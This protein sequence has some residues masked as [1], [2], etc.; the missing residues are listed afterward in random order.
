MGLCEAFKANSS[1]IMVALGYGLYLSWSLIGS[2]ATLFSPAIE[3]AVDALSVRTPFE[4]GIWI[5]ALLIAALFSLRP[6][7]SR[8]RGALAAV[9]GLSVVLGTAA[10][11]VCSWLCPDLIDCAQMPTLLS[12]V[13]I[14]LWGE[15][16]CALDERRLVTCVSASGVFSFLLVLACMLAGPGVQA[17]LHV[18]MAVGTV[19]VF[20]ATVTA[21]M[22]EKAKTRNVPEPEDWHN[23]LK[24]SLSSIPVWPFLGLGLFAT[25]V[26]L[27]QGFS[28]QK[29]D[30]PNELLWLVAGLVVYIVVMLVA[31]LSKNPVKASSFSRP[32]LPLLVLTIFLVFATDFGQQTVEVLAVGCSW[33]YFRFFTWLIW[34]VGTERP[35]SI[36]FFT[37]AVGQLVLAAG[38]TL[39]DIAYDLMM[40]N[41][42][43]QLAVMAIICVVSVL[44]A[45]Y[46]LDTNHVAQIADSKPP[47]DPTD[48]AACEKCVD[49][50]TARYGLS[51]RERAV[52]RMLV[53]GFDN[54]AIQDE[55]VIATTTMRTHLRNL[56][57]KTETHSREELVVLLRLLS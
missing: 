5:V 10:A 44:V 12:S 21:E 3:P 11:Y 20:F 18:L 33:V 57:R 9:A 50:A 25:M 1:I 31:L 17:V 15:R 37:I 4:H 42:M 26:V 29:A 22:P 43:P 51:D 32:I 36:P 40:A 38:G 23:T 6:S 53:Q 46:C 35:G 45:T 48:P 56:Y 52:A 47:F 19:A 27:L 13:F 41:E 49:V 24:G 16:I 7:F 28:E 55:L 39:G 34:R 8:A 30:I 54:Q 14:A 2:S